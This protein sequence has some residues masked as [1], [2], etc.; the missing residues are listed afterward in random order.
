MGVFHVAYQLLR[1]GVQPGHG[2]VPGGG[3]P[4]GV[5]EQPPWAGGTTCAWCGAPP[6]PCFWGWALGG[7][8]LITLA[9]PWYCR[10]V[11]G[12][13]N[14]L[15]R[16]AGPGPGHPLRLRGGGVPGLLRGIA[17]T[18]P[19]PR[20]PRCVEA[21]VKLVVG[22][23]GAL[24]RRPAGGRRPTPAPAGYWDWFP[25]PGSGRF[26][27]GFVPGGGRRRWRGW[28]AGAG[29]STLYLWPAGAPRGRHHLGHA[30]QR[31]TARREKSH[32]PAALED[33]PAGGGGVYRSSTRRDWWT[34]PSCQGRL[35]ALLER[36]P[37]RPAGR[38]PGA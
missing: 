15:V 16:H 33:H 20:C 13:P 3:V 34:P 12:D 19:P 6:C 4:A 24:G 14:A 28:P 2:G 22:L 1:P 5:G 29:V 9:A 11:I 31:P 23:G 7:M 37:Q 18:W 8:A 36:D 21:L 30:P 17:G 25:P 38:L 10:S 32:A 27:A 26:A 35:A